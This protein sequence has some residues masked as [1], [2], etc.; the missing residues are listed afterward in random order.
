MD[1]RVAVRIEQDE[2]LE[3]WKEQLDRLITETEKTTAF[4]R[5]QSLA[6]WKEFWSRSYIHINPGMNSEEVVNADVKKDRKAAAW[7]VGRNYQ[8]FRYMMGCTRGAKHRFCLMV[9]FSMWITPTGHYRSIA[10]GRD[11]NLWHRTNA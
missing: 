3:Q 6:W 2:T 1:L 8:L 10:I 7:Q 11:V 9:V 4:D 5:Q